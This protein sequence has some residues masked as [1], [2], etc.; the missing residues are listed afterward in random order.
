MYY[1]CTRLKADGSL[2]DPIIVRRGIHQG[3]PL[4]PLLFNYV[5]DWVL[6]DLVPQLGITLE[7][8][9]RLNHLAFADDVSLITETTE[10]AK[11]LAQQFEKGLGEVGLLPNSKKSATLAI[12]MDVRKRRWYCDSAA[13]AITMDARKRRRYCDSAVLLLL[14]GYLF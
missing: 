7:G 12:N 9:L 2:C 14:N 4:L 10:G 5:M 13:L 11:R 1:H 8:D 3:D 6:S